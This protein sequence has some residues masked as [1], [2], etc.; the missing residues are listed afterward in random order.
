MTAIDTPPAAVLREAMVARMV[1]DGAIR[2]R[3]VADA[4]RRVH[5][6][7]FLPDAPLETV[8]GMEAV[9]TAWDTNG[10]PTSAVSAPPIVAMMLEQLRVEPG[11]RVLEIGSGGYN[12]ALLAE[13]VGPTGQVTT[14]DIDQPPLDRAR[15]GLAAAGWPAVNVEQADGGHGLAQHAPYDRIVVT[16][17]ADDIPPAWIEQLAPAG[18]IVVPLRIRGLTQSIAF[19]RLRDGVLWGQSVRECGFVLLRGAASVDRR[20]VP[21]VG[22]EG[23]FA[24]DD[25]A[26]APVDEAALARALHGP[27]ET[28]WTG[29][30]VA[31]QEWFGSLYLWLA[32]NHPGYCTLNTAVDTDGALQPVLPWGSPAVA[33]SDTFAYLTRRPVGDDVSEFGVHA[34]GTLA[35][36]AAADLCN[37]VQQWDLYHRDGV[38]PLI[39][40]DPVPAAPATAGTSVIRKRHVWLHVTWPDAGT[41]D[42]AS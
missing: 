28:H 36:A 29:V 10:A 39:V 24:V 19:V 23:V 37:L 38:G 20:F 33:G 21:L 15:R 17:A 25:D 8:Y 4:M 22:G 27:R 9:V 30:T 41:D 14:I 6:H 35:A 40:A 31:R 16:G 32:T 1:A 26:D 7:L 3:R 5:R 13:L 18:R 34:H 42:A 12:A 2:T 11:Q